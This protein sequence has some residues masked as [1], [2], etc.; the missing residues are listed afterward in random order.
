MKNNTY[1]AIRSSETSRPY[2]RPNSE[3]IRISK[4][5][6]DKKTKLKEEKGPKRGPRGLISDENVLGCFL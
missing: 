3:L 1:D 2:C 4:V 6:T 5:K